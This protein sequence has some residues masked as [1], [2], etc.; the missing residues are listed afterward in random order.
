MT[1][2]QTC[3]L[4]ISTT[5]PE[6]EEP[7]AEK[8]EPAPEPE[9]EAPN[10]AKPEDETET[11]NFTKGELQNLISGL[12][13]LKKLE[14]QQSKAFGHIGNM[15]ETL[16]KL[17]TAQT[18]GQAV[19]VTDED[20]GDLIE[21][22]PEFAGRLKKTFQNILGKVKPSSVMQSSAQFDSAPLEQK[23]ED[24]LTQAK[25]EL[26]TEA[27]DFMV[28]DWRDVVKSD[29]FKVWLAAQPP[30]YQEKVNNSWSA[31]E[32]ARAIRT[33]RANDVR[34]DEVK[35]KK[36]NRLEAAVTPSGVKAPDT[37]A[38]DEED[39]FVSGFRSVRK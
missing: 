13:R 12:D 29:K 34:K 32:V 1:G 23:Y 37:S 5:K 35:Q 3:A 38:L 39:A 28:E 26:A 36:N 30:E 15:K 24:K 7:P 10:D 18:T 20:L 9:P 8:V 31:G 21:E 25:R 6:G 27:L 11:V 2:V 33:Y 14:D 17:Q 16:E 19:D 22:F 4:P